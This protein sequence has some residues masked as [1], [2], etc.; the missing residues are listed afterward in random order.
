MFKVALF[1]PAGSPFSVA[2]N[3]NGALNLR[4]SA[5]PFYRGVIQPAFDGYLYLGA[6]AGYDPGFA[7]PYGP[8]YFNGIVT[9]CV[10]AAGLRSCDCT[11]PP[12]IGPSPLPTPGQPRPQPAAAGQAADAYTAADLQAALRNPSVSLIRLKQNILLSSEILVPPNAQVTIQGDTAACAAA[13]PPS[14]YYYDCA[15]PPPPLLPRLS[16]TLN[17]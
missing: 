13:M 7:T 11:A 2:V 9:Y 1:V 10:P 8:R 14:F 15:H 3:T 16:A 5:F 17:G 6:G 4:Y 12:G